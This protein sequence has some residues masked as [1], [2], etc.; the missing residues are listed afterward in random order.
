[1]A[2]MT[3][4]LTSQQSVEKLVE[5]DTALGA[6]NDAGAASGDALIMDRVGDNLMGG[7]MG[8]LQTSWIGDLLAIHWMVGVALSL[9]AIMVGFLVLGLIVR[10][11]KAGFFM[12][13]GVILPLIFC[14]I[15]GLIY[16]F[17]G[18]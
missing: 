1:M 10:W 16:L 6:G 17:T 13:Y 18:G 2:G 5:N 7:L 12:T 4:N 3:D 9:L 14:V 8:R 15:A 11:T